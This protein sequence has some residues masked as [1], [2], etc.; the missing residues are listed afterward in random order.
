MKILLSGG[1]TMGSVSP[2]I[3][4]YEEF[5]KSSHGSDKFLF[6]GTESGPERKAVESYKIPFKSISSGK[7]RRYFSWQN[8]TDPFKIILGFFQA[9]G[10][11]W[12]FRPEAVMVAGAF[13]GV[14]VAYAA[15]LLH[16]PVIVHQQDI[17]AGLANKLMANISRKITVSFDVSLKDFNPK[18]TVLTGNPV[19]QEFYYCNR[20][21][22][23]EFFKLNSDLPILLVMGGGTGAK[24][25][26]EIM[27]KA[28]ADLIKFCQII[29]VT[30]HGKKIDVQ[31]DNYH[32]FEFL[33]SELIEALCV[34]DI[35]VS[36]CGIS[37]LSEL[38]IMGKVA[39]LIPM[40]HS[41]QEL[42][43]HY[44]QKHEAALVL[45][46]ESLTPAMFVGVIKD[47]FSNRKSQSELLS[48]NISHIMAKDGA[49]NVVGL[50]KSIVKDK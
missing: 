45:S 40:P 13:V 28:I 2:L 10:I 19:R 21:E 7:F 15:W 34:A 6:I 32:Q 46:Q 41:H 12:K 37:T 42:N 18:K 17:V 9:F 29:H 1:G 20:D 35:V 25:I 26:N 5:K 30:G 47:L 48:E 11:V 3:A 27:E 36:R 50:I 33:T 24:G 14:P 4:V 44:Y 22:S 23:R 38:S 31:S 8:F 39:I 16:I 49:K 43:A